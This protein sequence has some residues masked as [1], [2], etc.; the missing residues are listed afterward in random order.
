MEKIK[1]TLYATFLIMTILIGFA[2][3]LA[4]NAKTISASKAENIKSLEK[5]EAIDASKKTEAKT[6]I[7]YFSLS[8]NTRYIA[9]KI[10]NKLD[11]D[12]FE[13]ETL[14]PYPSDRDKI[15]AIA[16]KEIENNI[17]PELKQNI[18]IKDYNKIF[19][20]TPVWWYSMSPAIRT[21]LSNNDFAGKAI[22][23]FITH[24]GGGEY[25]IAKE[26]G[27]LAKGSTVL[28]SISFYGKGNSNIDAE[29][30]AWL[31]EVK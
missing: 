16:K 22:V 14:T 10:Q 13:L 27:N 6:L 30:N 18:D 9:Q 29:I 5:G 21:F 15:T 12:I 3:A 20:G 28:K 1:S 17:L 2:F 19:I 26:M 25:N 7:V 31:K 4:V 11:C 24:G 8:G 23:P